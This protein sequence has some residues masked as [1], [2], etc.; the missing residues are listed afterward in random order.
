MQT[1]FSIDPD[2]QAVAEFMQRRLPAEK[3]VTIAENLPQVARLLWS[4]FPQEPVIGASLTEPPITN[5]LQQVSSVCGPELAYADGGS[6]AEVDS[7]IS[8]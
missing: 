3:L 7:R 8:R 6:E 2:L 4:R 1:V 5:D